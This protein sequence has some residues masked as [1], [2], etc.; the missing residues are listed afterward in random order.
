MKR[1][2]KVSISIA[3][4][5]IISTRLFLRDL[6]HVFIP[7]LTDNKTMPWTLQVDNKGKLS[8]NLNEDKNISITPREVALLALGLLLHDIAKPYAL[9]G[10]KHASLGYHLLNC[11][12]I[13]LILRGLGLHNIADKLN[14]EECEI[15]RE[16][17]LVHHFQVDEKGRDSINN[18]Q[19]KSKLAAC[20]A[21]PFDYI[22]SSIYGFINRKC[23][24]K[25]EKKSE[26]TF[27]SVNPFTR[28]VKGYRKIGG[29]LSSLI[30]QQ[31]PRDILRA[32]IKEARERTYEPACDIPLYD[33]AFFSAALSLL[34][35][36]TEITGNRI[37]NKDQITDENIGEILYE[38]IKG[39]KASWIVVDATGLWNLIENSIKP[40]DLEA[41][42]GFAREVCY[43]IAETMS[44]IAAERL[45]QGD[46]ILSEIVKLLTP[47]S[48]EGS[49]FVA[50]LP[51]NVAVCVKKT[52]LNKVAEKLSQRMGLK[53]LDDLLN[54]L[55]SSIA[56]GLVPIPIEISSTD[57]ILEQVANIIQTK[58]I[59]AF[60]HCH[61]ETLVTTPTNEVC[62]YCRVNKIE[63]EIESII[64]TYHY[65]AEEVAI[66]ACNICKIIID[67]YQTMSS[68]KFAKMTEKED[69]IGIV[70]IVPNIKQFYGEWKWRK[71]ITK[72]DFEIAFN[73]IEKFE[74]E[75]GDFIKR[76]EYHHNSF[77][78]PELS[79]NDIRIIKERVLYPLR[80][81]LSDFRGSL[82]S[83]HLYDRYL[84]ENLC[85]RIDKIVY[86]IENFLSLRI[87]KDSLIPLYYDSYS[88]LNLL[89]E[90]CEELR[91]ALKD[92]MP[93][94]K[95]LEAFNSAKDCFHERFFIGHPARLKARTKYWNE[96][97]EEVRNRVVQIISENILIIPKEV[98]DYS[99]IIVKGSLLYEVLRRL[100]DVLGKFKY[101]SGSRRF[102][103]F[104]WE[105]LDVDEPLFTI[106]IFLAD[107]KYPLYRLLR[108]AFS[109]AVKPFERGEPKYPVRIFFADLRTGFDPAPGPHLLVPLWLFA[110]ML[111]KLELASEEQLR[112]AHRLI[113]AT[114]YDRAPEAFATV[115]RRS[116]ERELP[117]EFWKFISDEM[118]WSTPSEYYILA[119]LINLKRY[120]LTGR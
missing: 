60:E 9:K 101:F 37:I 2:L 80:K 84:V 50:L 116:I 118:V 44:S 61:A 106:S 71:D 11:E 109:L 10:G 114:G 120:A 82:C 18:K 12:N 73:T 27:Y 99:I 97:L 26:R 55:R 49:V 17:V 103:S 42:A 100:N 14:Q 31:L 93:L 30:A 29:D 117:N 46:D 19:L 20:F 105:L 108:T 5:E 43:F 115:V 54:V 68:E 13:A 48:R 7:L 89:N 112:L 40:R 8:V 98:S 15:V 77:M 63:N 59:E 36:S 1:N 67:K 64:D 28:I 95:S 107:G 104:A 16:V 6:R 32:Y 34:L 4:L 102:Q 91:G 53:S 25:L 70:V 78:K 3:L 22:A 87:D 83:S 110:Y 21:H 23:S 41:F 94:R 66:K 113:L 81:F 96:T 92:V 86:N 79:D 88:L 76:L 56:I 57:K 24:G 52:L 58:L 69:K 74:K 38:L 62:W 33:H 45:A 35:L 90:V 72:I 85:K 51:E 111:E 47:L 39:C 65:G 75:I 119:N